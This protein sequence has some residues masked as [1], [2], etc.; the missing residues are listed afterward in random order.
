MIATDLV[1][2]EL[3]AL[4][5]AAQDG[6]DQL[7]T[8]PL[9][10]A[11]HAADPGR[12]EY[13]ADSYAQLM[14]DFSTQDKRPAPELR[15]AW[16]SSVQR[17]LMLARTALKEGFAPREGASHANGDQTPVEQ[18]A[19]M[20]TRAIELLHRETLTAQGIAASRDIQ[21]SL[22]VAQI[23]AAVALAL[24]GRLTES[25]SRINEIALLLSPTGDGAAGQGPGK[26]RP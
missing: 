3:G 4:T 10:H 25:V 17:G 23:G 9:V 1:T 20:F 19:D 6:S 18:A 26:V 7:T 22:W 24:S 15:G 12:W 11:R 8:L 2:A 5:Q 21:D 16:L 14:R 13:A